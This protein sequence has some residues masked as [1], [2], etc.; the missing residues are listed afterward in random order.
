M[1]ERP[2]GSR[3][4]VVG[5]V[6]GVGAA[7]DRVL[8]QKAIKQDDSGQTHQVDFYGH[9]REGCRY[10]FN[11]IT[12]LIKR[13]REGTRMRLDL[14][15]PA[16]PRTQRWHRLQPVLFFIFFTASGR[17]SFLLTPALS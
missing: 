13:A 11:T 6:V 1:G 2:Q 9:V 10:S 7:R 17:P 8:Y 16:L 15:V 3:V 14:I 4:H 12:Q 5:L